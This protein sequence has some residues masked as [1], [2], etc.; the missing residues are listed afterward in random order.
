MHPGW[1]RA[2]AAT[3]AQRCQ[4]HEVRWPNRLEPGLSRPINRR[5]RRNVELP[6]DVQPQIVRVFR[7]S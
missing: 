3:I 4:D 1:Y 2:T 5:E 7:V 6:I